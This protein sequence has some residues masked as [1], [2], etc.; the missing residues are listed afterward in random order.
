MIV[1]NFWIHVYINCALIRFQYNQEQHIRQF[2]KGHVS[3]FHHLP[4]IVHRPSVNNSHFNLFLWNCLANFYQ[5]L[6][7]WSLDAVLSELYRHPDRPPNMTLLKIEQKAVGV[8]KNSSCPKLLSWNQ[9][10]VE[11]SLEFLLLKLYPTSP[12]TNQGATRAEV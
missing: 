3:F 1:F 4:S 7:E 6:V 10:L 12:P 9:S 2:L 11:W 8:L 5:T